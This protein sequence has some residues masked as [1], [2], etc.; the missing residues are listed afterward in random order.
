MIYTAKQRIFV[1]VILLFIQIALFPAY[2]KQPT[3]SDAG[4]YPNVGD[5]LECPDKYVGHRIETGGITRQTDPL[6]IEVVTT[7][8]DYP[9]TVTD[10]ELTPKTGDKVRVFGILTDPHTIRS[11]DAFVQPRTGRWYAWGISF[12]AGLWVLSRMIRYW[13]VDPTTMGF[14]PREAPLSVRGT[15][16]SVFSLD[17]RDDA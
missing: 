11:I 17:E 6:V 16:G 1:V 10:T 7:R 14:Y 8:G 9:I 13:T 5:I 12:L 2:A 4:V 15:L 3:N